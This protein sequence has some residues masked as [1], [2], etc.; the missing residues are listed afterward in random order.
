[1]SFVSDLL[2]LL[3]LHTTGVAGARCAGCGDRISGSYLKALGKVWHR[4]HFRCAACASPLDGTFRVSVHQEPFCA[5]HAD[6]DVCCQAC[7]HAI[8][9]GLQAG[10][11]CGPC[12]TEILAERSQAQALLLE[13]QTCLRAEGLPWWPQPFPVRLVAV[14][15]LRTHDQ[16]KDP[17]L[18]GTIHQ[19]Q[20]VDAQGRTTRRITEILLLQGRPKLLQGA[21]LAHELGHAWIFQKGITNLPR[22]VEEGFCEYCS[23]LWLGRSADSRAPFLMERLARNTDPVYGGGFRRIQSLAGGKGLPGVLPWLEGSHRGQP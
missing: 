13:V 6:K 19:S 22:D 17:S 23:H 4:E 11:F 5:G 14:D 3:G 2:S 1:M 18:L 9:G 16:R 20:Q 21:V 7:G 15:E 8:K 12:A 10:G